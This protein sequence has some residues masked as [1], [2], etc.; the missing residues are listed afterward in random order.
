M[1]ALTSVPHGIEEIRALYGDPDRNHDAVLDLDWARASLAVITLPYPM[2]LSWQP[3]T[4]VQRVQCHRLIGPAL[5]DALQEI[6][7]AHPPEYLHAAGLD[8]WG[9]CFN[10]RAARGQDKL[11]TH[12]WGIAVDINPQLGGLGEAP[13][14]PGF[15]VEAFINRG[16]EWGGSWK[17]P[18]AMHFQSCTGY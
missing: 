5:I 1:I 6:G 7:A 8:F 18:D 12:S 11:S 15:I 17:R 2:R 14:M 3:T 10:F 4:Y 13:R 9:G 16:F